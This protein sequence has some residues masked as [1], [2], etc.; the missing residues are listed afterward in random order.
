MGQE[1][2]K[3]D[4]LLARLENSRIWKITKK[5]EMRGKEEEERKEE[6]RNEEDQ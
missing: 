1:A 2:Q 4:P 6:E 3:H 5:G